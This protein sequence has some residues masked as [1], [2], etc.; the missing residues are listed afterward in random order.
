MIYTVKINDKEYEV[1]VEK[2]VANIIKTKVVSQTP[3]TMPMPASTSVVTTIE[4]VVTPTK[5]EAVKAPMPGTIIDIRV[6]QGAI[7][8]KGDVLVI[9]EAMKMENEIIATH[10]GTIAQISVIK[11]TTVSTGDTLVVIG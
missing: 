5:G 4:P 3:A 6:K 1:E 10:D 8:K 2:G 11:G 9:L 7:V